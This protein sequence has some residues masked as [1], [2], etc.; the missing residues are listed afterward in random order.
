MTI[1]D[2]KDE[3]EWCKRWQWMMQEITMNVARDENEWCK[4]WQ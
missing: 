2:A 4:R 1:N 3:N